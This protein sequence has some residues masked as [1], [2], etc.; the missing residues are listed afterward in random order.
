MK[1]QRFEMEDW[2][3]DYAAVELNLAESGCEDLELRG[4]LELCETSL[5]DLGSLWLGNNDTYGSARLRAA[6]AGCYTSVA[7]ERVL[8][9]NGTS[10][11]LFAFFNV[12][13]EAGDEVVLPV[14]AFQCLF[15]VPAAI[16]CHVRTVDLMRADQW[17]LD[18]DLLAEVVSEKTRLIVI[19]TPHNPCGWVL[20]EAQL[21]RIG[22]IARDADAHLL[23]D[24]HYRFL[25]LSS[26][27][28]ILPSGYDVCRSVHDMH[29]KIWA[30]GS[31]IKCFGCV[32][33]RIG[34]LIGD[35][36]SL[37]SACRDYK[38]YLSHTTPLVTDRLAALGLEHR[39]RIIEA[40]KGDILPN[41]VALESFMAE[42]T[43][44]FEWVRPEGG[45]V[46]FP[47]VRPPVD[48]VTL[49]R[50]L[51]EEQGVS[52]L[53]GFGFDV[54]DHLR[55]NFGLS[56]ERFTEALGRIDALLASES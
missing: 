25:P 51:I 49:C 31:M 10:E 50:R 29:E 54:V 17:R 37:L 13:L 43:D 33:I 20:D 5:D 36:P 12:L 32:G 8:V 6:I 34:W 56:R 21:R 19:N 46:C 27:T 35:D 4:Y 44:V 55:L 3:N 41:L 42:H 26:G 45:V 22:E 39:E 28:D 2:L 7:E 11:A 14:P 23:F 18:L 47:R 15:E 9:A 52:L 38:D 16:G 48:A 24:E 40:K 1:I 30:T 53:P